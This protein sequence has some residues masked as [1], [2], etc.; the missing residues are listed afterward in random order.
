MGPGVL[1]NL[2]A[3]TPHDPILC[4]Y[5]PHR[6]FLAGHMNWFAVRCGDCMHDLPSLGFLIMPHIWPCCHNPSSSCST[7][8][9]T[10]YAQACGKT[11]AAAQ[12]GS[13]PFHPRANLIPCRLTDSNIC[14]NLR[15]SFSPAI[16]LH[17]LMCTPKNIY[18]YYRSKCFFLGKSFQ[19]LELPKVFSRIK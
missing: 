6:W 10:W 4:I 12:G 1:M 7:N 11:L 17:C 2:F 18:N 9:P 8:S 19:S 13:G 5:H 3:H 15:V 16:N 14:P